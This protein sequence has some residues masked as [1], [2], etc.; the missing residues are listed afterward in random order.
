VSGLSDEEEDRRMPDKG[1]GR[2]WGAVRIVSGGGK[3]RSSGESRG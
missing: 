2:C 3:Y 1:F